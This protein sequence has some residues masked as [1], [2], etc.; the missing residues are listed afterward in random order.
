VR[1]ASTELAGL[2]PD[3]TI[4]ALERGAADG[5]LP[6]LVL[7]QRHTLFLELDID[8]RR[9]SRIL[10]KTYAQ[11]PKDFEALLGTEGVGPRTLRA[12][13]LASELIYGTQAS[14]RDPARFAFAHGGKD[15]IPF[16]VDRETYDKT[17]QVLHRA[18]D[19]SAIDHSE[20]RRALKRLAVF[21]R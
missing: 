19:R 21:E 20:K 14:T 16:P 9:L 7:P 10:L 2:A 13:A 15:G 11:P 1:H 3:T 18:V 5:K 12:L 17:I 6:D 8:T 4:A